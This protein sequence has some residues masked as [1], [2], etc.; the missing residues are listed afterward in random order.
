MPEPRHPSL[1]ARQTDLVRVCSSR[2]ALFEFWVEFHNAV[3]R[4]LGKP[5]LS[6]P[7]ALALYP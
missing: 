5:E 2:E 4:R 3:N 1:N 7:E 6:V